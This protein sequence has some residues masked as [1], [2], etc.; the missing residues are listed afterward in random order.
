MVRKNLFKSENQKILIFSKKSF[1][2]GNP[3][4]RSS[5]ASLPPPHSTTGPNTP[6]PPPYSATRQNGAV[7]QV[8]RLP[9]SPTSQYIVPNRE[10]ITI[11]RGT[12]A[13]HV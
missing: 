4:L 8:A 3:Y 10:Q 12:L 13:T 6:A 7:P 9:S 1:F 2:A 11:K 5:N